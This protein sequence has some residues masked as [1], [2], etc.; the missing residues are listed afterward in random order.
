VPDKKQDPIEKKYN[1]DCILVHEVLGNEK[2]QKL[3]DMLTERYIKMPVS[4]HEFTERFSCQREG[5]NMLVRALIGMCKYGESLLT[6][7]KVNG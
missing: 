6:K 3:L 1:L 7:G 2:G 5:E 4:H